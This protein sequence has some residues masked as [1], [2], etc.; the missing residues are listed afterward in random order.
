MIAAV[1]T[2]TTNINKFIMT[3]LQDFLF[4]VEMVKSTEKSVSAHEYKII[5]YLDGLNAE[6]TKLNSCSGGFNLLKN[7]AVYP[8]IEQMLT[9]AGIIY[10]KSYT[11]NKE[12]TVFSATYVF[13]TLHGKDLAI[14]LGNGD[15]IY[16]T[17]MV[18]N[19]YNGQKQSAFIFGYFRMICANGLVIPLE[20]QEEKNLHI[21]GKHTKKLNLSFNELTLK[22]DEF[23]AMNSIVKTNFNTI[24]DRMVVKYGERIEEVLTATKVGYTMDQ[25]NMVY[26]IV[27]EEADKLYNG[28][29]N[30][31]LVYNGIN[32]LIHK[33][34][35]EGKK[36]IAL[37]EVKRKLDQKV[38]SYIMAN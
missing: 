37:P 4:D 25:F 10:E 23:I 1:Y 29:V 38:L 30:D 9:D 22:I 34:L 8:P 13:Y 14:D 35:I 31:F 7:V 5:A 27:T 17:L 6:P 18:G 12:M 32:A 21:K 19:S 28:K 15:K 36:T 11:M 24:T 33:E 16:P 26:D 20:G 2:N 3:E